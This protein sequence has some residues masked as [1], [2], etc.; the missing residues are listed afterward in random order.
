[1]TRTLFLFVLQ[2][3]RKEKKKYKTR[4]KIMTENVS[5]SYP[6]RLVIVFFGSQSDVH[7]LCQTLNFCAQKGVSC[8]HPYGKLC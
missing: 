1:M 6:V 8:T 5:Q 3:W 7:G 4:V 2:I